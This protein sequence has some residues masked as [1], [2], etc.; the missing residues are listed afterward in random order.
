VHG[1]GD[2]CL[3]AAMYTQQLLLSTAECNLQVDDCR[4]TTTRVASICTTLPL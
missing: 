3:A 2:E 4:L 1:R